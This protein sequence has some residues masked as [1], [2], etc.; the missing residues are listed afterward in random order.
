MWKDFDV[1][2]INPENPPSG[3]RGGPSFNSENL[4][5]GYLSAALQRRGAEVL[6]IDCDLDRLTAEELAELTSLHQPVM[7]GITSLARSS[8]DAIHIAQTIGRRAPGVPI[9]LG[10][11]HFTYCWQEIL[12]RVPEVTYLVRGEG[13]VS[14][15]ELYDYFTTGQGSENEV[16][17]LV[18][19]NRDRQTVCAPLKPAIAD[20]DTLPYPDR[21]VLQRALARGLS[22]A[23]PVLSSRGCYAHCLF[24]NA[25]KF[26]VEGGGKPWRRRS[27][28]NVVDELELLLNKYQ[29]KVDP[30]ILFYDDTF[31]G[32]GNFGRR[33]GKEVAEEILRRDVKTQFETF[34]RADTFHDEDALI[35]VLRKSGMVRTFVGIE[36]GDDK[37]LK[38]FRKAVSVK[39]VREALENL[40]RNRVTTPA[41][42]FIMFFPYSTF[43]MLR[44][45]ADYLHS[46]GHA[47]VWNLSTRLDVYGGNEFLPLLQ[48]DGLI[49]GSQLYGGYYTYRF[50]DSRVADFADYMNIGQHDVV[51]RLDTSGRFIEFNYLNFMYE[52]EQIGSPNPALEDGGVPLVLDR[53]QNRGYHFFVDSL[54]RFEAGDGGCEL[55]R[56]KERF[57][58]DLTDLTVQ[59]ENAYGN[60]LRQIEGSLSYAA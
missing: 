9:V 52:L 31:I 1:L 23:I 30:V 56:L 22:P 13:E 44:R 41:S 17:G 15:C 7:V 29:D 50:R 51:Q 38:L 4:A 36:A 57:L 35:A 14:I 49:T 26:Y 37:E 2:L 28:P 33:H 18:Y 24:C 53:L 60:F 5:L 27:A 55:D 46:L 39:Q 40:K 58:A 12:E 8:D 3:G 47:S 21:Q 42:G 48:K 16:G 10:G 11:L 45:N 19:R 54:D 32:P 43:P 59:L 20:L 34:L 6:I 25:T